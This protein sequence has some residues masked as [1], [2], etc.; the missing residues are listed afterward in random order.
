MQKKEPTRSLPGDMALL[1]VVVMFIAV[2]SGATICS[3]QTLPP[4]DASTPKKGKAERC[5]VG[6]Y[7]TSIYDFDL[8]GQTFGANMWLW[9]HTSQESGLKPLETMEFTNA[10]NT[11]P[12]LGSDKVKNGIRWGQ[13]KVCG[14]FNHDWDLRNFPFDRHIIEIRIEEAID[15]TTTLTYEVDTRN[16]SY[17]KD[18]ELDDWNITDFRIV[19]NSV[20]HASTF[21]DPALE[22]GSNSEYAGIILHV[23]LE[24]KE[25]TSYIKLT[26]VAYVACLL[27]LVSLFL[28]MDRELRFLDSRITLQAGALFATVIN[29]RTASSALGSEDRMTLVDNVHL[30]A[31]FYILL[32]VLV[33]V[34]ARALAAR[35]ASDHQLRQVDLWTAVLATIIFTGTNGFLLIQAASAG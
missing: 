33:T 32:G 26:A 16:S 11:S 25:V 20:T 10:Q 15:D 22:P 1:T 34:I 21:G 27:L 31:L 17:R 5:I 4:P 3:A 2:L 6:A 14:T 23:A 7:L 28:H 29:M 12:F 9:T 30:V 19:N 35:G 24:R 8:S 13:R 18:M